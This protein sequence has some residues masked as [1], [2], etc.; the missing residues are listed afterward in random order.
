MICN[1]KSLKFL[2]Q[3]SVGPQNAPQNAPERVVLVKVQGF[4]VV[5]YSLNRSICVL[6]TEKFRSQARKHTV[7]VKKRS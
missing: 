5:Q 4:K 7:A 6:A 2:R 1:G 3:S